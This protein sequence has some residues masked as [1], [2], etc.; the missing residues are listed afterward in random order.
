MSYVI[1]ITLIAGI[2]IINQKLNKIMA[3]VDE[4]FDAVSS[5]LTE[6]FDEIVKLI[7]ELRDAQG[8]L[9]PEQDAKLTQIETKAKSLADIVP[10]PEG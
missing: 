5:N 2:I 1:L 8:T 6:G 9:T 10:N 4:R 3:T 7:Q